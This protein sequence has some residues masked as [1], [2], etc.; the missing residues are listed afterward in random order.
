MPFT[1]RK[2]SDGKHCVFKKNDK[3][4]IVGSSLG[5]HESKEDAVAQIGAIESE[6]KRRGKKSGNTFNFY[7]Q[8]DTS[9]DLPQTVSSSSSDYLVYTWDDVTTAKEYENQEE[10]MSDQEDVTKGGMTEEKAKEQ[11]KELGCSGAHEMPDGSYMPCSSHEEF[12]ELS[13]KKSISVDVDNIEFYLDDEND[14]LLE[15]DSELVKSF[16]KSS[17]EA[18]DETD[19]DVDPRFAVKALGKNRLGAYGILWGDEENQDLHDEHFTKDTKDIT[20]IF[21][22]MGKVPLVVHHAADDKVKT[23]VYGEVDVM[24]MDDI[25]L[26]YEAKIKEFETYR[27]YVLP[28]LEKGILFSSSGT[29]PAAKRV[30]KSGEIVRWPIAEM[31]TTWMPAEYRMLERPVSEIKSG[32]EEIGL[33]YD[34]SEYDNET[35]ETDTKGAEKARL[36]ALVDIH[37]SELGLLEVEI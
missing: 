25:G 7:I 31:T 4:E 24:E 13:G 34:L 2:N 3:D 18:T 36:K 8:S 1:I 11:A 20:A 37:L 22:A 28:F 5:C 33:D 19:I 32:Y 14:W 6:L 15:I 21:N 26:W 27:R 35:E 9:A 29:L 12:V 16:I 10:D 30:T 23:F 17:D